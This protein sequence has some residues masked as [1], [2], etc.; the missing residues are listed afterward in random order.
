MTSSRSRVLVTGSSGFVGGHIVARLVRDGYEVVG[1]DIAAPRNPLPQGVLDLRVDIRNRDS[2]HRA[3]VAAQ[4]ESIIHAAAQA[5]VSVSMQEPVI[6]IATN[7]LGTMH[8]A[9]AA[10]RNNVR[11]FVFFSTGGALL[12][13]PSTLPV[14]ERM[15]LSAQPESVYGA[16]KLAAERFLGLVM[17]NTG[18]KLSVLRPG[19]IYGP[20]QDPHGEAGV[21]AIFAQRML[22]GETVT[23]FGD[24]SQERD[25]VFVADIVEAAVVAMN[26]SPG[27]CLLGTGVGTSTGEI[28]RRLAALTGYERSPIYGPER[29]GDIQQI[30]LDPRHA[31]TTWG[32]RPHTS[33]EEGLAET[34]EW[35]RDRV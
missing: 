33:I 1:L 10:I 11:D 29:P 3:V 14:T 24:G 16:S 30:F 27:T 13:Q 28:F 32:W 4:P 34:V 21:V 35:F 7:V 20:A 9:E 5:S 31:A 12:G 17:S 8:L 19:N 6:D 22:R 26:R 25:Y 18:V 15:A 23:I 2:V